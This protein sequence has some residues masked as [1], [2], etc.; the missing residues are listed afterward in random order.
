MLPDQPP[1]ALQ[2]VAFVEDHFNVAV[3][4]LITLAGPAL[5]DT[6]GAGADD[7]AWP[8][9]VGP[10]EAWPFP[11]VSPPPQPLTAAA[12]AAQSARDLMP[13]IRVPTILMQLRPNSSRSPWLAAKLRRSPREQGPW[14]TAAHVRHLPATPLSQAVA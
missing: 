2:L 13:W 7:T 5:S 1:E 14:M 9:D 3:D 6:V 12:R 4:P 11:D 8:A 10:E